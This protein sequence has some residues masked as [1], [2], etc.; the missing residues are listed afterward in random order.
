MCFPVIVYVYFGY[1]CMCF[2]VDN[3]LGKSAG[4]VLD[5]EYEG[6]RFAPKKVVVTVSVMIGTT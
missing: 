4:T 1:S 3:H 5:S 2:I 6:Q